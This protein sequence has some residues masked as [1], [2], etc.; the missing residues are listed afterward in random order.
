M[1]DEKDPTR[2]KI[3][4]CSPEKPAAEERIR[5]VPQPRRKNDAAR[6]KKNRKN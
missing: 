2:L 1:T 4:W 3:R 6:R 5:N